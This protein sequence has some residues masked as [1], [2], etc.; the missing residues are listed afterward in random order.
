[1]NTVELGQ[2]K[3]IL[4]W[5]QHSERKLHVLNLT[6]DLGIPVH[7]AVSTLP[8]GSMVALGFGSHF[9]PELALNSA[10]TELIQL[11]YSITQLMQI[12]KV[13]PLNT[14]NG[15]LN[16]LNLVTLKSQPQ[17]DSDKMY[18]LSAEFPHSNN[19][20]ITRSIIDS[21]VEIC[22]LQNFHLLMIDLTRNLITVP[23]ARVVVPGFLQKACFSA[24]RLVEAPY[25][26]SKYLVP[27]NEKEFNKCPLSI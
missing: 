16:W 15:L 6:T 19:F 23:C 24:S 3:E 2:N 17:L 8:D 14:G 7:V 1:L 4:K 9:D 21:C 22:Q 20:R 12:V 11:E 27:W 5:Y 13:N 26:G 10:L 18:S 25:T